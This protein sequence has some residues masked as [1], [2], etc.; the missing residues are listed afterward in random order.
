M[1]GVILFADDFVFSITNFESK[2][3]HK[4][5]SMGVP[6]LPIENLTDFENTIKSISTFKAIILDWEFIEMLGEQKFKKNPLD[7][8]KRNKF[9][10]LI[11][12]YSY[13]PIGIETQTELKDIFG[14]KIEFLTKIKDDE[15]IDAEYTKI[16][17][18]IEN[19]ELNNSH[20]KVPFFWSHAINQSAQDIFSEL[21]K[22]DPNW[23]KEIYQTAKEDGAEPNIE[24]IGV[25]QNLLTELV[26]QNEALITSISELA[27]SA[28]M[29]VNDKEESLAKLYH[30]I[31]YTR[32][33]DNAPIMTGDI[34]KFDENNSAILITPECDVEQKSKLG[35]D[36]FIVAKTS[37]SDYL[38]K[39]L[40]FTI[41][42]N[43]TSKQEEK[44]EKLFNQEEIKIHVLPSFPFEL[45]QFKSS[46]LVDFQSCYVTLKIED[47][48]DK[49]G[50]MKERYYKL[51]SPHIHQLRQRYLAYNGRIGVPAMPPSL[52]AY[53]IK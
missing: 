51:N 10:S 34:F 13:T 46:A 38:K 36:F 17:E 6:V 53:N 37:F 29:K 49:E 27:C 47:L 40:S 30:R 8:L 52:R 26:I 21:E 3:F 24:V 7:I 20:L 5:R 22:A 31:Y 25:F 39:S 48:K 43:P 19:F 28:G 35:L 45:N 50:K 12:I 23:I 15:Q 1:E 14:E 44:I 9:Y 41:G 11:F 16:Y 18:A 33:S 32:V 4:I 42:S 2:L